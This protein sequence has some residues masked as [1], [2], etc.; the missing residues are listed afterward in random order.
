MPSLKKINPKIGDIYL[1]PEG[2]DFSANTNTEGFRMLVNID[3]ENYAKILY[4]KK[5][6]IETFVLSIRTLKLEHEYGNINYYEL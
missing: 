5:G 3:D 2:C 6:T 4:F 1:I